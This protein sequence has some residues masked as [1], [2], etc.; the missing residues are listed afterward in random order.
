MASLAETTL[1]IRIPP[2]PSVH[3]FAAEEVEEYTPGYYSDSS[4][5]FSEG[6]EDEGGQTPAYGG[7]TSPV[8]KPAYSTTTPAY[9]GPVSPLGDG[10]CTPAY[11]GKTTKETKA[12]EQAR[13]RNA[14]ST[15]LASPAGIGMEGNSPAY[16]PESPVQ[17]PI[18]MAYAPCTPAYS[19]D[20]EVVDI[21]DFEEEEEEEDEPPRKRHAPASPGTSPGPMSDFT[22]LINSYIDDVYMP[23]VTNLGHTP[24]FPE[25]GS[26]GPLTLDTLG[27]GGPISPISK[28]TNR[29]KRGRSDSWF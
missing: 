12:E 13:K 19:A 9:G 8:L 16:C 26:V 7:P 5:E 11:L 28:T 14:G 2:V 23:S 20:G 27:Y 10:Q 22:S 4:L 15:P 18:T 24:G 25:Y 3:D 1:T 17:G 6:E 21:E 29:M